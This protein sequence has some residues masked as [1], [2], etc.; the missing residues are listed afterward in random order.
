[1]KY[2]TEYLAIMAVTKDVLKEPVEVYTKACDSHQTKA[3]RDYLGYKLKDGLV[4][5]LDKNYNILSSASLLTIPGSGFQEV[6]T[7]P[8]VPNL[9]ISVDR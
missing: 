5:D 6:I 4:T 8:V 9:Q 1:M 7:L 3:T 2:L